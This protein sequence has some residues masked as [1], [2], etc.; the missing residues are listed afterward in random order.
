MGLQLHYGAPS[1]TGTTTVTKT[2]VWVAASQVWGQEPKL[3]LAPSGWAF[4]PTINAFGATS[5]QVPN[6]RGID[7]NYGATISRWG[8]VL[9][10]PVEGFISPFVGINVFKSG[11]I[12]H[13]TDDDGKRI[14]TSNDSLNVEVTAAAN[15]GVGGRYDPTGQGKAAESGTLTVGVGYQRSNKG[16]DW[17]WG[18]ELTGSVE[19][20]SNITDS[21]D[22]HT[23]WSLG[24]RFG[25]G[26]MNTRPLG[27]NF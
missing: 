27:R 18:V 20:I 22:A 23:E 9:G 21:A 14:D 17:G 16:S 8:A 7:V 13:R 4:N 5:R 25:F 10:E 1:P 11:S 26:A 3:Q 2:G 6:V 24:L 12:S 19:G 15:L